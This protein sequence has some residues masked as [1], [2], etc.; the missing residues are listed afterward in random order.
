MQ[1]IDDMHSHKVRQIS[2]IGNH[3]QVDFLCLEQLCCLFRSIQSIHSFTANH[4]V[5]ALFEIGSYPLHV[6]FHILLEGA[7]EHT[8]VLKI[9]AGK[10]TDLDSLILFAFC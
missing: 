7:G 1:L 2:A 3:Q 6:A 9:A 5:K 10:K 8:P 4:V